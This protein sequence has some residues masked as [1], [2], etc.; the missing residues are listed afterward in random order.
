MILVSRFGEKGADTGSVDRRFVET[1][2]TTVE[3]EPRLD[4]F[5]PAGGLKQR[6]YHSMTISVEHV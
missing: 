3:S 1:V 2:S 4:Q 5:C 6:T